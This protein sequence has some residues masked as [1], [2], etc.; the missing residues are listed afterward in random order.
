MKNV[1]KACFSTVQK[2]GAVRHLNNLFDEE[3]WVCSEKLTVYI[4][5]LFA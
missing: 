1:G 3:E 2:E 4:I 5:Y